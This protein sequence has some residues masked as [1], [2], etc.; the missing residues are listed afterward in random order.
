MFGNTGEFSLPPR[1]TVTLRLA[2]VPIQI[3]PF[4]WLVALF[5]SPFLTPNHSEADSRILFLGL[6]AWIA[7]WLLKFLI[8]EL[9]HAFSARFLYGARPR[10]VLFG[11]GGVTLWNPLYTRVPGR[12]GRL[13]IALAGPGAEIA[14]ALLLAGILFVCGLPMTAGWNSF[15]PIPVPSLSFSLEPFLAES[16][17]AAGFLGIVT[18]EI[19]LNSFLWMGIFWGILNLLPIDPLDGGHIASALF[20]SLFSRRGEIFA[21]ALSLL[22]AGG[23]AVYCL[24]ERN[25]FMAFFFGLFAHHSWGKLRIA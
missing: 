20:G 18:L 1:G 11:F 8:H 17:S 5:F 4:F 16:V 13:L 15:G 19:F 12:R 10:I 6:V 21:D 25:F 9:G 24:A 22:F 2:G 3:Q 14:A 23:L 7:A